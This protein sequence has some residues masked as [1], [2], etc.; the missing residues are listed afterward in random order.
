[1][2][3]QTISHYKI[4]EKLGEGGMGIVYKALDLHQAGRIVALKVLNRESALDTDVQ[5]RFL[6]E[7]GAGSGLIH[8]NIVQMYEASQHDGQHF[9]ALEFVDGKNLRDVLEAGPLSPQRAVEIGMAVGDALQMAHNNGVIHRDIKAENVMVT[10]SGGVK[11]MDF[12]LAKIQNASMLTREGDIVGTIAYMSPEQA[13]GE[14]VD[15]RTDIFSFGVLLYELL[16]GKLPFWAAYETAI[17]YSILNTEPQSIREIRPDVP[18]AL[19]QIVVKALR[20]DRQQRYQRIDDLTSDLAR[21][22]AYFDGER[23]VLPTGLELVAGADSGKEEVWGSHIKLAVK[24]GF[25]ANL[26]GREAEFD[27]LKRSLNDVTTGQGRSAFIGGEAGIGKTRLVEELESYGKTLRV[28][29]VSGRCPASRQGAFPYQPFVEAV[30][31]YLDNKNINS[32]EAL[33]LFIREVAP[34]LIP[35]LS[36]LQ[37]F[38]DLRD[39]NETELGSREQLWDTVTALL[40]KIGEERPL[41]LFIDDLHW[42]DEE[43][44]RLLGYIIR[45][46][47]TA[48]VM[49]MGTYRSDEI[50][51]AADTAVHPLR[52]LLD[53]F[54]DSAGVVV[55]QLGRLGSDAIRAMVSSLFPNTDFGTPFYESIQ[56]ETEGNPFFVVETLKLL[57]ME[58]AI[59]K[60]DGVYKLQEKYDILEI[61]KSIQDIVMRRIDRLKQD[62]RE[63]LEIGAVEG[64]AF[65]SGT[66]GACLELSR[67][68]LLKK[69]QSLERDHHIIHPEMDT[70]R[71]DH[72]KIREFLYESINPELRVEY[73]KLIGEFLEESFPDVEHLAANIAYHFLTSGNEERSLPFLITAGG[74]AKRLFVNTQAEE[75]YQKALDIIRRAEQ[76]K[77]IPDLQSKKE[78]VLEGL[79]DVWSLTGKHEGALSKYSELTNLPGV[80]SLKRTEL[81]RKMGAVYVNIGENDKALDSLRLA[82]QELASSGAAVQETPDMKKALGRTRITRSRVLKSL[83]RYEEAK[84]EVEGGLQLI[85]GEGGAKETAEALNNLGV[86]YEDIGAYDLAI[87]M[88]EKSLKTREELGD[89]K[90]AAETYNNIGNVWYYLGDYRQGAEKCKKSLDIMTEIGY[91]SGI[92]GTCNN[93]GTVY[94]DQGRYAEALQ[95]HERCLALRKEIGDMPGVAMSIGNIG[96]VKL[97]L[98]DFSGARASLEENIRM[99]RAMGF[100]VF[101]SQVHSW[102]A[103]AQ[104][105]LDEFDGAE[106]TTREA[107]RIAGEMNQKNQLAVAH[108]TRGIVLMERL[109]QPLSAGREQEEVLVH[110]QQSLLLFEE[111][112][113]LHES[114]RSSLELAKFFQR[115]GKVDLCKEH[116]LRSKEIFQKLGALGDLAIANKVKLTS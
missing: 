84:K 50:V 15:H 109:S 20:K 111:L 59:V 43:T 83:G 71:F 98:G 87:Q 32:V 74:W 29:M 55:V 101:E 88:Y 19:E 82:E 60:T 78:P 112:K 57:K 66:V 68:R 54:K 65:H 73:H 67:V 16:S 93:L 49:V 69:L 7:S 42:A 113:M 12:G 92:A 72:G 46:T 17:V 106:T 81:L 41:I 90:G 110:L 24:T 62:E 45:N 104:L 107:L 34:A 56:S 86:I 28:R 31:E 30:R 3:G 10:S 11:V 14:A 114:G 102:L 4:T 61:P 115:T 47:S 33:S 95:M 75:Y 103:V 63:I 58:G 13:T 80:T 23:D 116:L 21:V 96:S 5:R 53:E 52:Q 97:D 91:R 22:K 38:L 94:Q 99:S 51:S 64:E 39:N 27:I 18:E 2:I 85:G 108:R 79:A 77:S 9:I 40:T 1:M 37:V 48:K 70:Y 44:V 8:P 76:R 100:R 26:V 36:V 105:R 89:K 25:Q 6:R 35:R